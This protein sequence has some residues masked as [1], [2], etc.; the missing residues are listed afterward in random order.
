MHNC[1]YNAST[2]VALIANHQMGIY[3]KPGTA[4]LFREQ[5]TTDSGG[6]EVAKRM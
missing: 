2:L 4:T 6:S 1:M 3:A 5:L